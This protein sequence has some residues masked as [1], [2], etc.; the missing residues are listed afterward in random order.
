MVSQ[1]LSVEFP[2]TNS[3]SVDVPMIGV[4]ATA[5]SMLPAS[6]LAGMTTDTLFSSYFRSWAGRATTK[7]ERQ[8]GESKGANK[9]FP[10]FS[11]PPSFTGQRNRDSYRTNSQPAK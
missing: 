10:M 4:R 6:F 5:A 8:K 11:T 9:T 3:N 1:V 2:S 7:K